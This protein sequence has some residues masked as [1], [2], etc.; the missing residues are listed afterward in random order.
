MAASEARFRSLI[1]EAPFA[2]AL[3]VGPEI[4]IDTVN[5]AMLQI[6][7]KSASVIGKT[8]EQGLPELEGQPFAELL[9]NV[10][11]TGV[12]YK[13]KEQAADLMID[14][15]MKRGWFNFI[16]KPLRTAGGDVYAILHMAVDI[17]QQV[18]A[19]RQ[20]EESEATLR[21]MINLADLGSYTIDVAASQMT[22]SPRVSEWYGLPELTSVDASL[23][24]IVE[25]DRERVGRVFMNTLM[26][27]SDGFYQVEYAVVNQQT[28]RRYMLR[29]NGQVRW[30]AAGHPVRV[31]GTVLDITLQR[32]LQL[33]LE[34]QVRQR[35]EEL[36]TA[37]EQLAATNEELATMNEELLASNEELLASSQKTVVIN[38]ELA[39]SNYNLTR[40]NDNLQQFAYVASH[41]LQ[42][43]LRKIQQFGDLLK[44][45]YA[46][47]L[48][49]G[50]DL[51]TRMQSAA[52]RM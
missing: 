24:A 5:E 41:D 48:G 37:N 38:E 16:Y 23:N 47:Q 18:L 21:A 51:L 3:Y 32:E 27:G 28:G 11:Q 31:D 1:E 33:T 25:D 36:A 45:Q 42:E 29:T 44:N 49:E 22:K 12:E 46:G 43:P 7:G 15:S 20:I 40:S 6:W 39:E 52:S 26:P 35:T 19:R 30:N 50:V 17:T 8:F 2:T 13:T 34:A 14:G 9:R 4:V 10:F